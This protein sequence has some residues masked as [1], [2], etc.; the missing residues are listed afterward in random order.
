MP[1]SPGQTLN[2][3]YRIARLLGQ[4]GFGA[5][6]RIWDTR[7]SKA[8]ALKEDLELALPE[9]R[10]N[11]TKTAPMQDAEFEECRALWA[12]REAGPRSWLVKAEDV[13]ANNFNLDIKNPTRLEDYAH[14]PPEKLAVDIAA[15]EVRIAEIMAEIQAV[16]KEPQ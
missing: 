1:L 5:V 13:A 12:K 8:F 14:M 3:R 9:G 6:Y 2:S 7:L 11:Y 16:L 15:K 10:K 4:G